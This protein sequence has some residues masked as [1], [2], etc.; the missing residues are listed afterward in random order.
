[1]KNAVTRWYENKE[2]VD[3]MLEWDP[4]LKEWEKNV[5]GYF[6]AGAK[7]LDVGCGLGRE[8]FALSDMGYDVAGVDIS[9]EVIARVRQLAA[10][11]GYDV[12]FYAYNGKDL[13][14]PD[15]SFDAVLVWAQTFGLLYGD[16]Y[17]R[18]CLAEWKRVLRKGGLVSFSAHDCR[19]LQQH[20]PDCLEGRKFYPYAGADIFWETFKAPEL[21]RFAEQAGLEVV[22]CEKG[23]IYRPED[24]TVLHCLCRK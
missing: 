9:G 14:F 24:G 22:L 1:M 8:A 10:E 6:P 11:R 20:H 5:T 17:K 13:P 16:E 19:Y 23:N 4:A 2:H 3:E 21:V 18:D 7:I 12:P 15:D